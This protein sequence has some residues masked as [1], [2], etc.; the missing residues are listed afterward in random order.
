METNYTCIPI[1]DIYDK[2]ALGGQQLKSVTFTGK[3]AGSIMRIE[4]MTG[5]VITTGTPISDSGYDANPATGVE[6]LTLPVLIAGFC[7][8]AAFI[9]MKSRRSK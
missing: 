5:I 3:S 1:R 6:D 4:Y 2:L 7:G 8:A 9:S